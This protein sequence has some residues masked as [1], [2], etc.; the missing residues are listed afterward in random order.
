MGKQF[1]IIEGARQNNLKNITLRIPH[2]KVTIITGISG[3]G[4]SSLAFDTLFA[5]GQWRYIE[6]LSTYT[7]MFIEKID[8]PEVDVIRNIRP[9]IAIEQK[10]PV[11][12]ARSTV[13]TATEIYDYLR[14]LFAKIGKIECPRCGGEVKAYSPATASEEILERYAGSRAYILAPLNPAREGAGWGV[15]NVGSKNPKSEIRNQELREI[16]DDLVHRGF[17]RVKIGDEVFEIPDR[18]PDDIEESLS[19]GEVM[20]VIDRLT[21]SHAHRGR[22]TDSIET[23]FK[24]GEGSIAIEI[25]GGE[26]LKFD[27][28]FKCHRCQI[29]FEK[30]SPLLFSFNHPLGACPA[31]K[32]FGDILQY[33]EDLIVPDKHLSLSEGAI[34]PWTKPSYRWWYRQLM[35]SAKKQGIDIKKPYSRLTKEEKEKI[36]KGNRDFEGIHD[37]FSYLEG[38]RY[39]LHVRVFLSRY[40]SPSTCAACKG[41]RLR[42]EALNVK[43]KGGPQEKG[44]DIHQMGNM[45]VADL[46]AWF[47][48]LKITEFEQQVAGDILRQIEMKLGFLLKIGLDYLTLNRQTR[49]LSGGEAQ[50]INLANQLGSRLVGT[51]YVLDEPSIGLHARDTQRLVEIIRHISSYGNT[52]IVVEHDKTMIEGGDYVVEMGPRGGED[53]GRVVFSG[54]VGEFLK[55]DC[56]TSQYLRGEK[57]I[58][59]P[60]SRRKGSG[61]WL[62]LIGAREHNLKNISLKIPLHTLTCITGV[63]G[64]GKST[65]IQDTLYRALARV[66]KVEFEKMGK[67]E[68]LYG[69]EFLHGVKL[70]DQRPIGRTPRSN[71]ITY[72]KA[73]DVIRKIFADQME[74]RMAGFTTSSFSFN[75]PGGRCEGCQGSGFQKLEMYF[76]EDIYVTCDR[77]DGQRYRP[78]VL[79]V[80]YKGKNISEVLQMTI[81]EAAGFFKD[82][83]PLWEKLILLDE[84]GLGYLRLG[85]PATT[86]SGGEA[87]RLKIC[88]EILRREARDILYL[89][90]EPTT[91]LHFDDIR[92]LIDIFN[93]LVESGNT[94]AVIEHN[95]E[96]I[97][98]ADHIIDLG[99]E[100]GEKGGEIVAEGTPEE[101]ARNRKSYTGR[102]LRGYLASDLQSNPD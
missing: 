39:K 81:H 56:L 86:L 58:P 68:R 98:S 70:I 27:T 31:C 71:P 82:C 79:R 24:E 94:V 64:S 96:V 88:S 65:L 84:V 19:R 63:S 17:F 15:R 44:I 60:K 2:N 99:P 21:I 26:T 48:S 87:Q 33:D 73:F 7:R 91:G 45:P 85:Q 41:T 49:T 13:G 40:R 36:F 30:P 89:L 57:A 12:T 16:L 80:R 23:A 97:K 47:Q 102:Y 53:G 1:L 52:V 83:M 100:G 32:G 43:I 50:R 72:I 92:K 34:E 10:N 20:V 54:E 101:V 90:D 5:E 66:F 29:D 14:L 25:A 93:R 22:V 78:E 75:T 69:A 77:C 61:R 11:R 38:K 62:S 59:V 74:S 76:F 8:R 37:F 9:A 51:L 67:F 6:S 42:P 46:Y 4:K 55:S 3:S 95:M 28:G 18:L 35:T